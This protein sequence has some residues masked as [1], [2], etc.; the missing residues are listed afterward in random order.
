MEQPPTYGDLNTPALHGQ[1]KLSL[2]QAIEMGLENN[3][4]IQVERYEPLI[5]AEQEDIAWGV[6]DPEWFGNVNHGQDES[7]VTS[8]LDA[9]T[10]DPVQNVTTTRGDTGIRGTIPLL[11]ITY[12]TSLNT[13][14][15]ETNLTFQSLVPQYQSN[16]SFEARVPLLRNLV[17]N[18]EWTT[19]KSSRILVEASDERF[20]T[21]VMDTVQIIADGYW[22]LIAAG[23]QVN[24]APKRL[25]TAQA[26][27][28]QTKTQYEVGV[29]SKVEVVEAEAGVADREFNLIV[30]ENR[31]QTSQ[32]QLIDLVL[33]PHLSADSTLA[34]EPTDR[35]DDYTK[36]EIDPELAVNRAFENR[37]ELSVINREI[38]EGEIQVKFAKN[39]RLPQVDFVGSYGYGGVSGQQA[40][41]PTPPPT[42]PTANPNLVGDWG[43]SYNDFFSG[44]G[45]NSYT[46]GAAVSIPLGNTSARHRVSQSEL[47]LRRSKTRKKRLEQNIILEVREAVRDLH[48]AQQGIEA[49]ERRAAAA[50]EQLRAEEIKL[51]YGEST[52]FDVLLRERDFVEAES[53]E[54][55]AFQTYRT[56][57]TALDR[58]QGTILRNH[59]VAIDQARS[60]R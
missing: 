14:R 59:N 56:S 8:G 42:P 44:S 30:V 28:D 22:N 11:G 25:E 17:W 3:L 38:E 60:L 57:A 9:T 12:E 23:D 35:P 51:E 26:L 53:S 58:A 48:S 6:Y 34:F 50:G 1:L 24:V 41:N 19:V 49:A 4:D 36:Y 32:D 55:A 15:G 46:V 5:T 31:Y 47:E 2:A 40:T 45:P 29:V 33:G 7:W 54:I 13:G 27:L 39:Q 52:P 20:R 18:R 10:G 21:A 37:P 16:F 43:H